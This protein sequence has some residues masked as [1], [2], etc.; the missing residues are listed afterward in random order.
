[1]APPPCRLEPLE[2]RIAPAGLV[3]DV[4]SL[5]GSNGFRVI[6]AGAEHY[7]GWAVAGIGDLNG[8]GVDDFA[9]TEEVPPVENRAAQTFVVF[10]NAAGL[11]ASLNPNSLDGT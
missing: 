11:P 1:M 2:S 10:G 8:D 4:A 9:F 6:G 3:L 7:A 5:N